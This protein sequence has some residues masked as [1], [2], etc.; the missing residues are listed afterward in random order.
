W[1]SSQQKRRDPLV[2][3]PEAFDFKL[4]ASEAL[5]GSDAWVI[6]GTPKPGY[7]PKRSSA[8]FFPKVKLRVWVDKRDV[9]WARVDLETLDTVSFL[10]LLFRVAKGSHL[11]MEQARVDSEVWL[12]TRID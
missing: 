2:E 3:L 1:T 6:D 7:K 5:N 4:A 10:G 9:Q 12:P 11:V 8:A